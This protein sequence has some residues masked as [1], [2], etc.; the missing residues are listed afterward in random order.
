MTLKELFRT[1]SLWQKYAE[2]NQQLSL[3]KLPEG[4]SPDRKEEEGWLAGHKLLDLG[5]SGK[6]GQ[7]EGPP[8]HW[9]RRSPIGSSTG[10]RDFRKLSQKITWFS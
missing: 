4:K 6:Q 9:R 5:V 2:Q 7:E 10:T 3:R 1:E 8:A